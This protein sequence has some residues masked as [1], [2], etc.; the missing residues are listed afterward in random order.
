MDEHGAFWSDPYLR[1][2]GSW[3]D[4]WEA[5]GLAEREGYLAGRL[6][7]DDLLCELERVA[8][9]VGR[10][11]T[12]EDV[13]EV[14]EH[15]HEPFV[16]RFG[17]WSAALEAAGYEPYRNPDEAG[18]PLR[19]GPNWPQQRERALDRDDHECQDCGRTDAEHREQDSGGLHVHH[20]TKLREFEDTSEANRLSN[21]VTLCRS[22]HSD[23]ERSS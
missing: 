8:E 4:A 22:C 23:R 9:V 14:G 2:F 21:L 5:A 17:S 11:P 3:P 13:N 20:V 1:A 16:Q 19:Y 12:R 10:A 6:S 18:D 15:S 7:A